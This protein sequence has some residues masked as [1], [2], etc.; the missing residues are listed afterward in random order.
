MRYVWERLHLELKLALGY[1]L[2]SITVWD[3]IYGKIIL[4][5]VYVWMKC[6]IGVNQT[7]PGEKKFP[8]IP[9][10]YFAPWSM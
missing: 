10:R 5:L 9:S 2:D 1:W 4:W 8:E 7:L 3:F 6:W